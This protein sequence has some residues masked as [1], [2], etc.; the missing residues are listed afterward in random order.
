MSGSGGSGSCRKKWMTSDDEKKAWESW[1]KGKKEGETKKGW[2]PR[3]RKEGT[4]GKGRG[5]VFD[6]TGSLNFPSY[7]FRSRG[8]PFKHI[9]YPARPKW[10]L[11]ASLLVNCMRHS[12][13][14]CR[15]GVIVSH[16]LMRLDSTTAEGNRTT[17]L[18]EP[19]S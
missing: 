10:Q 14:S 13:I 18:I 2:R 9:V 5:G 12:A 4:V 19:K 11:A 3:R 8:N 7:S 15:I 16:V 1:F 17:S 6:R